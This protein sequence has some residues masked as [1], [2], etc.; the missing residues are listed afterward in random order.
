[1]KKRTDQTRKNGFT[2][3][4]FLKAGAAGLTGLMLSSRMAPAVAAA[5]RPP[6]LLFIQ[7]DQLGIRALSA[8]GN[9]FVHT[10][11]MDRLAKRGVSFRLSYSANPVCC[12]A[13]SVWYTGR[14]SSETGVV[15]NEWPIKEDMPDLG[16]WFSAR[17]YEPVYAGKWHVPGRDFNKSF[18]VLTPGLGIGEHGDASVSRAAEGFFSNSKGDKPFFLSLGFLQPHDCCYFAWEL[19]QDPGKLFYPELADKPFDKLKAA[20][21]VERLPPLPGNFH[22][23]MQEPEK[24]RVPWRESK[25]WEFLRSW[26]EQHWRYYIWGYYRHVEMVDAE[27]GRVLDALEDSGLAENTMVV[28]TADHGDGMGCHRTVQKGFLYEE[29][30][31]VPFIASWPGHIA[32]GAQ[33]TTHLVSGMD[34]APTLCDYA[35]IEAP[36][37]ARGRS[38]RPLL[39][40]KP[41]EW[42]E[43]LVSESGVTGRMVRTAD[44]KLIT[45]QNDPIVQLFDMTNDP[46]ETK[47]LAGEARCAGVMKDLKKRL[48]EWEAGLEPLS[49]KGRAPIRPKPP[50]KKK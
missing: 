9:P 10:P 4:E 33:D 11:N 2:R 28:F 12:P 1:M 8:H 34:F 17:G 40:Q 18:R 7:S 49:L 25:A 21:T 23:N 5:N 47:N 16:Q 42:R 20:S 48:A 45:Y 14:A 29:A 15:L 6:N 41:T 36:P 35:G 44:Y 27:I 50:V 24:V 46:W 39:E 13:R 3:R 43:F 31:A 32:E 38:L 22:F 30:A 37:K 26:S 19:R